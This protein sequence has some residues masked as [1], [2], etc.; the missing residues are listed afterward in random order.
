HVDQCDGAG[1]VARV[2]DDGDAPAATPCSSS[3]CNGGT[4]TTTFQP[5]GASCGGSLFC[6]AS[7]NCVGC[8]APANC[9]GVDGDCQARTCASGVCG[10][11]NAGAG[12]PAASQVPGDCHQVQCDGD[13]GSGSVVDDGDAPAGTACAPGVCS[14]GT[15]STPPLP[16]G[17]A[18]NV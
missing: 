2:I 6:D 11:A 18:C 8:V 9:P 10:V 3:T 1:N 13:G 17:S 4:P 12:T 7:G 5:A 14:A 15:P 16:R